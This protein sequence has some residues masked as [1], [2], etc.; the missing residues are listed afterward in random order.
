MANAPNLGYLFYN[1]YF[2]NF[3]DE[4]GNSVSWRQLD[5]KRTGKSDSDKK[6]MEAIFSKK[7]ES[8]TSVKLD[9]YDPCSLPDVQQFELTTTYPGLLIGS[10]YT[11]ETNVQGEFKLGFYF[12][13][14]TGLPHIPGSSVKGVLRSA[15]MDWAG[16]VLEEWAKMRR[17]ALKRANQ[18]NLEQIEKAWP[19][20][21]AAQLDQLEREIF[22]NR[23]AREDQS[24]E[25]PLR[26][27]DIFHDAMP[28][29]R[30]GEKDKKLLASDFIT[31]HINRDNEKLSPFSD[32][33]PIHFMKI[34]PEV[35]FRFQFQLRDGIISKERK[36]DLFR[37]L[38]LTLGA[39]AKT[40]V[41]YGQFT[42][43]N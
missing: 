41:G 28:V 33:T 38:L 34:L 36:L 16:L 5:E 7:N 4:N 17:D 12:D 9:A 11:H 19:S 26:G 40:N 27:K 42:E 37:K 2:Q 32:P 25:S 13:H 22:G 39:G 24:A 30:Q 21:D 29:L 14:A 20:L 15:F 10:G 8:L 6:T 43:V 31:P 1:R 35:T 18:E 3:Q 23:V